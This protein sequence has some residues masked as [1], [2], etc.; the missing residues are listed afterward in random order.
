MLKSKNK[1]CLGCYEKIYEKV[2]DGI[3]HPSCSKKIFG[4]DIP[5]LLSLSK[6]DIQK[7]EKKYLSQHQVIT[8][9]QTKLSLKLDTSYPPR[10]TILQSLG[11]EFILK[12]PQEKFS[13]MPEIEDLTMHLASICGVK[14]ALHGLLPMKDNSLAYVTKRFDRKDGK[15]IAV[16]DLCQLSELLTEQKYQS[17]YERV[18]KIISQFTNNPGEHVLRFF[19]ILVFSFIVGN[20]DMHLKNFSLNTQ[21]ESNI[22]LSPAYDLLSVRILISSKD[23]PEEMAL[24]LNG[25]KNKI[26]FDDFLSLGENLKI[27]QKV[28][29]MVIKNQIEKKNEM[30][31]MIKKSFVTTKNKKGL[32]KIIEERVKRLNT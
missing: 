6:K 31:E 19:E 26:K 29:R 24:N 20:N 22:V 4:K 9:V 21:D 32:L 10:L 2:K 25:K 12:P 5:P 7:L 1:K 3:Y 27:P 16:E 13:E 28:C 8:G 11:G 17:S 15:K 23:D 14:T 30:F 18:G